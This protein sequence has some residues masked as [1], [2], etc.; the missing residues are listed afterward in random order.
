[1]LSVLASP[2]TPTLA[3]P[4]GSPV[5]EAGQKRAGAS[6]LTREARTGASRLGCSRVG[7]QPQAS[8]SAA[9]RTGASGWTGS[10]RRGG[11]PARRQRAAGGREPS[12]RAA[13]RL[14]GLGKL[15]EL[16]L[17]RAYLHVIC[18]ELQEWT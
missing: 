15:T 13:T 11:D 3:A 9:G 14:S 16:Q 1:M 2:Y 5:T 6:S 10:E 17:P 8:G 12:R 18:M 7:V 4:T